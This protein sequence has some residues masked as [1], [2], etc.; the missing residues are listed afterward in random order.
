MGAKRILNQPLLYLI[1]IIVLYG[2]LLLPTVGRQGISWDEQTDIE[3]ARAY[4]DQQ[5]G[6]FIGSDSDPSQTRLPMYMVAFVYALTGRDDLLT[7][8]YISAFIGGLTIIGVYVFCERE[9]DQRRG[10]LA[11]AILATSPFFLSF[12]R[13]AFTETDI[14]VACIFTWLLVTVVNL[15]AKRTVGSTLPVG[16]LLGLAISAKFTAIFLYPALLIYILRWSQHDPGCKKLRL[17][18]CWGVGALAVMWLIFAWYSRRIIGLNP[19][20]ESDGVIA[21]IIYLLTAFWWVV[22]LVWILRRTDHTATPLGLVTLVMLAASSTFIMFPPVH[23]TNPGIVHSLLDRLN[24]EMSIDPGFMIEAIG[25]HLGSVLF[26][27]SPLVG[28]GLLMVMVSSLLQWVQSKE[29][30]L[31]LLVIAF[32]FLGLAILPIAQTFYMMP[33][34][35]VLAILG[36]DG[37][38]R[39]L[40]KS[41]S[42]AIIIATASVLVLSVD[43]A[44]CYPDYNL[45]GYQWLGPRYF[46]GRP[47]I[48]YRSIVQTTSDGVQQA[49]AWVCERSGGADRIVA[50]IYPWHIVEATCP[51]LSFIFV[52]GNWE[53]TPQDAD[54][55]IIHINHTIREKWSSWFSGLENNRSAE[56]IYWEPYDAEW[57]Q[58]HYT[59]V[60]S[61]PRAFDLE[62]A[63]VWQRND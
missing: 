56:R 48:G 9:F 36:A 54:Y 14:Y 33:L 37:W 2:S 61:V 19:G 41:R 6:W 43:L 45:N 34:L 25:T 60:F 62:I 17:Q 28:F 27:S 24:N 10:T 46:V 55:V 5:G 21:A 50:F 26:K 1:C 7:A 52:R 58:S 20:A 63:S 42:L 57:L 8:R 3:I 47:T 40:T 15:R 39:L 18:D 30:R 11:A 13:T 23:L 49:V 59:K 31:P 44:R 35:P 29:V 12:A 22:I 4:N 16:I 32:Y 38:F 51:D 53:S